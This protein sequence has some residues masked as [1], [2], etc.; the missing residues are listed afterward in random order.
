[1]LKK[2][3]KA[4]PIGCICNIGYAK[5]LKCITFHLLHPDSLLAFCDVCPASPFL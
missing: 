1:M 5:P 3:K 4:V 2:K